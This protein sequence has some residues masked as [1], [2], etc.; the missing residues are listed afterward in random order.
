MSGAYQGIAEF[1]ARCVSHGRLCPQTTPTG[2]SEALRW[3]ASSLPPESARNVSW[4][5]RHQGLLAWI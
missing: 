4:N 2:A 1:S 3:K 5:P